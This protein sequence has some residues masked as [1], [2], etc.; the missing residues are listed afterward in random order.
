MKEDYLKRE[1]V[2]RLLEEYINGA[3]TL[4][5]NDEC[6]SEW[7]EA[8]FQGFQELQDEL[9]NLEITTLVMMETRERGRK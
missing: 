2:L 3:G 8:Q 9:F 1:D 4:M 6:N 5:E 7:H